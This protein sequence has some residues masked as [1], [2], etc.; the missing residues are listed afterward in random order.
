MR[1]SI[2]AWMGAMVGL[3][4]LAGCEEGTAPAEP[5]LTAKPEV[6]VVSEQKKEELQYSFLEEADESEANDVVYFRSSILYPVFTKGDGTEI[7]NGFVGNLLE[8]FRQELPKCEENAKYDYEDSLNGEFIDFLFPEEQEYSVNV[9]WQNAQWIVLQVQNYSNFGGAH[10]NQHGVAYV[11]N[12]TDG[13][14]AG[15][16]EFL[17]TYGLTAE[18]VA[19]YAAGKI[20]EAEGDALYITDSEDALTEWVT[21][22]LKGNQWYPTENGLMLFANPYDIAPYAYGIIECEIPYEVLEQGL[23]KD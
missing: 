19:V 17:E 5:T 16:E 1:K 4:F 9:L 7:L 12:K 8:T 23:K 13:T 20:R 22:F 21:E 2:I 6:T 14:L 18:E 10:P 15:S 3:I 11:V